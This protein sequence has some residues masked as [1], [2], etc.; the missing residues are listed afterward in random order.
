M[1]DFGVQ[2]TP[3]NFHFGDLEMCE[4]YAEV[5]D[6]VTGKGFVVCGKRRRIKHI[7]V[8]HGNAVE[9]D[10]SSRSDI[11]EDVNEFLILFEG[12]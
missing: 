4:K 10:F 9:I 6:S 7:L 11:G 8:S 2:N 1:I 3:D 5:R 12:N